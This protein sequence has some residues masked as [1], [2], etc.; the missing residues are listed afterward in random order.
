LQEDAVTAKE[1][2]IPLVLRGKR[3]DLLWRAYQLWLILIC[4][5]VVVSAAA[6]ATASMRGPATGAGGW[7][8]SW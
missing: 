5:A 7:T 6:A 2:V 4:S 8:I 3:F 1:H